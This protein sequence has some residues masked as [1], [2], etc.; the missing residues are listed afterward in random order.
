MYLHLL[1][2]LA[3]PM[4]C[5]LQW[6][7]YTGWVPEKNI[8]IQ[9]VKILFQQC[10]DAFLRNSFVFQ[11]T[12]VNVKN[13]H[14]NSCCVQMIINLWSM[15]YLLDHQIKNIQVQLLTDRK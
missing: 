13:G 14:Y 12:K 15:T 10:L 6:F 9:P 3:I 5:C 2:L 7:D 4:H 11:L 1:H 8:H